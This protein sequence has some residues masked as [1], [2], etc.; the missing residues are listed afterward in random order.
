MKMRRTG[1]ARIEKKSELNGAGKSA[2]E[3]EN[4]FIPLHAESND[5]NIEHQGHMLRQTRR[6][7]LL[8]LRPPQVSK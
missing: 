6:P 1:I 4:L 3:E 8:R 2:W 5:M 7:L